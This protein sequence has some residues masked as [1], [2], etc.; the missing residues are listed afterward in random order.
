M[1]SIGYHF[2]DDG[3]GLYKSS[4]YSDERP[5]IINCAG[6]FSTSAPIATKCLGRLDYYFIYVIEGELVI[7]L[8]DRSVSLKS[9]DYVIIPPDTPYSYEKS[10]NSNLHYFWVHFTGSEVSK[11]I[12]RYE[13]KLY[14]D[15]NSASDGSEIISAMRRFT[16]ACTSEELYKELELS[17]LFERILLR[18]ARKRAKSD[19]LPLKK[20]ISHINAF[21]N[22]ELKIPALARMEGL[23]TSRYNAVFKASMNMTP[24][25]YIIKTRLTF[26]CDL[27]VN[28]DLAIK[29]I[30]V[31]VGYGDA[32]FFSRIFKAKTGVSPW[33]YRAGLLHEAKQNK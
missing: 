4:R 20:S 17:I 26:A 31:L 33:E 15:Y 24:C 13:F 28:T 16:D 6:N 32:H 21:Y 1:K 29:E 10:G 7:V 9:G 12:T 30:S 25:E 8:S 27:L 3:V 19:S 22:T 5:L 14:P 18:L 11:L 2:F 23:S